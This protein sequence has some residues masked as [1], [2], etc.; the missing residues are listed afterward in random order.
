[1]ATL[2]RPRIAA[3]TLRL[4]ADGEP[5]ASDLR[6]STRDG[7][8]VWRGEV[9][10][11]AWQAGLRLRSR[12]RGSWP[13]AL[14]LMTRTL[15]ETELATHGLGPDGAPRLDLDIATT[16]DGVVLSSTCRV[17]PAVRY[18]LSAEAVLEA[19]S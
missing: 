10:P 3:L 13:D 19:A 18:P 17:I 1:M 14:W 11:N 6:L 8:V 5:R 16:P 12:C 9:G 7:E 2:V 4:S 15:L